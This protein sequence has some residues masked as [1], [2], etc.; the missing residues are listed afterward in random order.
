MGEQVYLVPKSQSDKGPACNILQP[1]C[2]D[3]AFEHDEN[4]L[5]SSKNPWQVAQLLGLSIY[6][7][8]SGRLGV[9]MRNGILADRT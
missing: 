8:L 3:F 1:A 7:S 4:S 2:Q 9:D 6:Q 5:G